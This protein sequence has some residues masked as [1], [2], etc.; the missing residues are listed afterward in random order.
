MLVATLISPLKTLDHF[1]KQTFLGDSKDLEPYEYL[2]IEIDN[3]DRLN[4]EM[5]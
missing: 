4:K 1:W 5:K 3:L 2:L